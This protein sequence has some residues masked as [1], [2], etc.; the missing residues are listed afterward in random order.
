MSPSVHQQSEVRETDGSI[1]ND[2]MNKTTTL[3][4]ARN[5]IIF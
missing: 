1:N 4:H 3:C 5:E 2:Q